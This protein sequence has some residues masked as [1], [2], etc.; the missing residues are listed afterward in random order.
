MITLIGTTKMTKSISVSLNLNGTFSV[1]GP[2]HYT[3]EQLEEIALKLVRQKLEVKLACKRTEV[4]ISMKSANIFSA[5]GSVNVGELSFD[6]HHYPEEKCSGA[7]VSIEPEKNCFGHNYY[8]AN[9]GAY[10]SPNEVYITSEK[11]NS[12]LEEKIVSV[13]LNGDT[14]TISLGSNLNV[15]VEEYK[16]KLL[17]KSFITN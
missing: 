9:L 15:E 1:T 6:V 10:V 14:L 11:N 12:T 2:D 3:D 5:S 8:K 17:G 13:K 16:H 7:K 4:V